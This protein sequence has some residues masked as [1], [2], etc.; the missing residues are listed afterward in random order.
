MAL[1]AGNEG[2]VLG[3]EPNPYVF[4]ILQKNASLNTEHTHIIPACFAATEEDGTYTF[5]YS[6]ASFCN[7]GYLDHIES[8]KHKHDYE[9]QVQGKNLEAELRNTYAKY[10]PLL[11]LIKVDAEGY[12]KEILKS[13]EGIIRE[14]KP[15]LLVECYKRLTIDE[16]NDLYEVITRMGY[17]LYYIEG[18]TKHTKREKLDAASM[19][20]RKHFEMLAVPVQV[21]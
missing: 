5:Q 11:R 8:S 20:D 18:F 10:L 2:T 16:R 14:F 9:L 15:N 19:L 13:I 4:K 7:G 6:D 17:A 21:L 12:D 1:A 3:L